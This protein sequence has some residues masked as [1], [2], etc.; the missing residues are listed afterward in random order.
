MRV[1]RW[2]LH[3]YQS[4]REEDRARRPQVQLGGRGATITLHAPRASELQ[5]LP[6]V[7]AATQCSAF[8]AEPRASAAQKEQLHQKSQARAATWGNTIAAQR[9]KKEEAK[10]KR[11]DREEEARKVIDRDEAQIQAT[12][13][14]CA[15]APRPVC[16]F[17]PPCEAGAGSFA[18]LCRAAALRVA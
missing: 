15:R 6:Q 17:A 7:H 9:K 18:W 11:L 3:A 13:R 1:G 12:K 16:A 4:M 8:V 5:P 14:R 2:R 10:T